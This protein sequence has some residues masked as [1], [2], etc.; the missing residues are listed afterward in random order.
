VKKAGVVIDAWKL[1]IFERRLAD[2]GFVFRNCGH[3][4]TGTLIVQ[5]DVEDGKA[6]QLAQLVLAANNE[7]AN[8][9]RPG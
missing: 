7:A 4:V 5:V 8:T 1:P 2:G 3:F 6:Q 9:R